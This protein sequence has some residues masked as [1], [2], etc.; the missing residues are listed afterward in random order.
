M[1]VNRGTPFSTLQ[2]AFFRL[3]WLAL[4]LGSPNSLAAETP[5][6]QVTSIQLS[7]KF[8]FEFAPFIV[9]QEKGYY[10]DAGLN[11]ELREWSP[12]SDVAKDVASGKA[13][14]GILAS[15]LVVE[16]AQGKP[17][18]ALA[19]LMQ[20]SAVALL[21]RRESGIESV[22]DL[23]GKR[24]ATT[25]DTEDEIHA[26]LAASGLSRD[27]YTA[28][29]NIG[30]GIEVLKEG[31]ADAIA[32]YSSNEGFDLLNHENQYLLLSPRSAGI[33]LFGNILFTSEEEITRNPERVKALRN[34][35]LKGLEYALTHQ[36]EVVD[37][38]F[39]RYNTQQKSREHLLFESKHILELTRPD[40]VE[41]GYMSQGRWK[42]VAEVYAS[43]GKI[44]KD[45]DLN[46]FIYDPN[47]QGIP[48]FITWTLVG[49][50]AALL[51]VSIIA[52]QFSRLSKRLRIEIGERSAAESA[53]Q[54]AKETAESANRAKS[55]FLANMS[56]EI[57][58][59]MNGII[60]MTLLAMEEEDNPK[61]HERMERAHSAAVS[62]LGLLN[63]VLDFSKI[64]AGKLELDRVDF[65]LT[66]TLRQLKGL[67][68]ANAQA[69]GLTFSIDLN[70][71]VHYHLSGDPLRLAQILNNLISNALKFTDQGGISLTITA[72]EKINETGDYPI[73]FEVCDSGIGIST[74]QQLRIFDAFEQ[75]DTSISRRFGGSG[76][77]LAISQRL[78]K[79]MGGELAVDSTLGKGSCFHFTAHFKKAAETP[80]LSST[81]SSNSFNTAELNGMQVLLMEDNRLNQQVAISFLKKVG[82]TVTIANDGSEGIDILLAQP[83]AFDAILMDIQMPIMDG[84]TATKHIRQLTQ[85]DKLP[86]IAMT[87]HAM[88][89]DR[90]KCLDA[91]MQDYLSK[92]ID[93][94]QLYAVLGRA[95]LP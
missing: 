84:L 18:V 10:R 82:V 43:Q 65:D 17:L 45:F 76:L 75:A 62:L 11:V 46:S 70:E 63:D 89:D 68:E 30:F 12:A 19:S 95:R 86:I 80:A 66:K 6:G 64:E 61:Q 1:N 50:L 73:R 69:K 26:Y 90:Q 83:E 79:M 36:D 42:H 27:K 87:A 88:A 37:L 71:D 9:A 28:L 78:S 44:P 31:K 40:I 38:I 8:Q 2:F 33:D 7:W 81:L 14:Y 74:E 34:A 32:I 25:H 72:P 22:H 3:L 54:Q 47:P 77:G 5:V 94:R 13:N 93:V 56:H 57:R 59:P 15:S 91:G 52:L 23:A 4:Y 85:F 20:H 58:T 55:E 53:L 41:P 67:F 35:T 39:T 24:V 92:P 48:R 16:R 49:S 29:P 51:I 21:A 60:G